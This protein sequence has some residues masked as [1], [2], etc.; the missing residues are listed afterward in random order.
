MS[1]PIKEIEEV[2]NARIKLL[3][4]LRSIEHQVKVKDYFHNKNDLRRSIEKKLHYEKQLKQK[5]N[6]SL[7]L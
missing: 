4:P 1:P 3:K 2:R 5:M 6:M 7:Q